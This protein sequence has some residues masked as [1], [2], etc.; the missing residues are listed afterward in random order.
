MSSSR[1]LAVDSGAGHVACGVF[2]SAKGGR[3]V[4]EQFALESFNPDAA[5]EAHWTEMV[6]DSIGSLAKQ[7]SISGSAVLCVPGHQTLTKFVKTPAV[8][9]SKRQKVL[10]FEA[11]QNIPY[12][13]SEVVWDHLV[14]SDDGLDLE[15]MLAAVKLDVMEGICSALDGAKVAVRSVCPSALALYRSFKYNYPEVSEAVLVVNIGARSTNL[16]FIDSKRFFVRTIAQAGNTVTQAIAD[17]LKQDFVHSESLKVQ[18]LSG[19]S[20]LPEASPGRATVL[21][22]AHA[23]AARL[24]LEITRS[25][26]NYRRQSGAD[27]PVCVYITGGGSLIPDLEVTLSEKLKVRVER[28]DTLR[29]VDVSA[30]AESAR[31][32]MAVL[33]DLVGLAT[34][35]AVK[36]EPAFTLLPPAI[37]RDIAFSKQQ[38][39]YI[40]AAALVA[41][42][43]A[44]P[45]WSFNQRA[46]I[47]AKQ[48]RDLEDQIRPLRQL[49]DADRANLEKIEATKKEVSAIQSLVESKSNWINFLT[50]LQERLVKVEDVWLEKLQVLRPTETPATNPNAG[51]VQ[52]PVLRLNVSGRLLDK[53]NPVSKVSQDSYN[54]VKSLLFSFGGSQFISSVEKENFNPNQP[55]I[56]SFDF[57]LVVNPKK[58]L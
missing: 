25:T 39:Y 31:Q 24:H 16:L 18:V 3:L 55:G 53:N 12:P 28:F 2:A 20:E 23:F 58:P 15:V 34:R 37:V 21:N 51:V 54:R 26:V 48:S 46:E 11:Q 10:Q 33:A 47:T 7:T 52:A 4:L 38:P 32:H 8:D 36:G 35:L 9:K 57:I 13:L 43:L 49:K 19:Q 17:E 41:I 22:A 14:V 5:L 45:I 29:N 40:G 50:D 56:L 30:G 44:L 42:A 27:Q 6:S 1:V